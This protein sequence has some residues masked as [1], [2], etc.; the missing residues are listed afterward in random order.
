ALRAA[1]SGGA[2][3][4]R[5]VLVDEAQ[6]FDTETLEFCVNLLGSRALDEQDLVI[7]ADSA[8]NIFR[9]NFK[10]KDAG[11]QAQGRTRI[12]RVNYRNT[13][14]ILEFAH[15]FLT[16]DESISIDEVP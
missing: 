7:V 2:P 12:L 14:Q 11:V 9:K 16:A 4:Y 3:S 13:R 10:W 8:Q 1:K 5:A 6:D 15:E